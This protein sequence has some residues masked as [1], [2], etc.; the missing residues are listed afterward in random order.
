MG[1]L[2]T[3]LEESSKVAGQSLIGKKVRV[4]VIGVGMIGELHARIFATS[5]YSELIVVCDADR[6]R[7][8]NVADRLGVPHV[9]DVEQVFD[10][11]VEAIS[12]CLP[13][14][15]HLEPALKAIDQ[16]KHILIEKPLTSNLAEGKLLV[17][18]AVE[19]PQL[20]IMVGHI[21]RFD[22]RYAILKQAVQSGELGPLS[23][24]YARRNNRIV[25]A[26]R[27]APRASSLLYLG[28]H[29]L[30][31]M[32]WFAGEKVKSVFSMA[33][34]GIMASC[35]VPDTILGLLRFESGVLGMI[36]LCWI[37]PSH[38][39][40]AIDAIFEVVG[41]K[42]IGEVR[43]LDQGLCMI[44]QT[45][46]YRYPDTLHW[47][48][49]QGNVEGDLRREIE[50]FLRC[51]LE[52][53]EVPVPPSEAFEAVKVALALEKS[54]LEGREVELSELDELGLSPK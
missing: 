37:L 29:D 4:G 8:G 48:E 53:R 30:D 31:L 32:L 26:Q 35:E 19:K 41:E 24:F 12:I 6:E 45:S 28:V 43:V 25:D 16:N 14:N 9:C 7:G 46:H 17:E 36:E 3:V 44:T 11:P 33:K 23:H 54:Y 20:K 39:P 51:I 2:P 21:L 10:F 34:W 27:I 22:P 40:S 50:T 38:Y 13:E 5:P 18:R 49:I 42:G 47:P 15:L 1:V 52:D